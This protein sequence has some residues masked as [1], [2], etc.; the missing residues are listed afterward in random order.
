MNKIKNI[1][2]NQWDESEL[3]IEPLID[4]DLWEIL[5]EYNPDLF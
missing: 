3:G 2:V 5:Q 4:D 1:E